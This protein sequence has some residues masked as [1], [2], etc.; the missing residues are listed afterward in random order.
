MTERVQRFLWA[1]VMVAA[2]G[3]AIATFWL[4]RFSR[5]L[6]VAQATSLYGLVYM[7]DRD[8]QYRLYSCGSLG[9]NDRPLPGSV[10][11][12]VLPA[13]QK[14]SGEGNR[15]GS[16]AFLRLTDPNRVADQVGMSGSVCVLTEGHREAI[17]VSGTI[18]RVLTVAPAWSSDGNR[19]AFAAV[20]DKNS[21]GDFT[22]EET[23]LYIGTLDG[24][25][26]V[27]VASGPAEDT[28]LSWSPDD[29]KLLFQTR[30][31]G[32]PW[33]TVRLLDLSDGSIVSHRGQTSLACWS[34]DGQRIAA[35]E[36]I[37]R[38]IDVL[39]VVDGTVEFSVAGPQG[40]WQA[41]LTYLAWLPEE[42][43]A[44]RW[45]A[46]VSESVEES[47]GVLY[48]RS[49][50]ANSALSWQPLEQGASQAFY[51]AVSPD[52]KWIVYNVFDQR[53]D[54]PSL[55]VLGPDGKP[56]TLFADGSFYGLACWRDVSARAGR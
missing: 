21:D 28:S 12:D 14:G 42:G 8:G 53:T 15:S 23:G 20:E 34:P 24:R 40:D 29:E 18:T 30:A 11:G 16:V 52:G 31:A 19:V 10:V 3:L 50:D 7:S 13:C 33:P 47:P 49:V 2:I 17:T 55:V 26:P 48:V 36:M 35:Y 56:V 1:G 43:A 32:G 44:G 25:T 6:T 54:E 5:R 41:A 22:A 4:A 37:D 27:R 45:L 9:E 38:R 51:P 39:N 46:L